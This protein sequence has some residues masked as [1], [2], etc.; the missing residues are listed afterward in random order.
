M[1]PGRLILCRNVFRQSLFRTHSCPEGWRVQQT[2]PPTFLFLQYSVFKEQTSLDAMSW[3]CPLLA[4]GPVECRSRGSLDFVSN[5]R[6]TQ[7]RNF[8]VAS[9]VAAVVGEAYI[10]GGG[11]GV[12]TDV[13]SFLNFFATAPVP[14]RQLLLRP[15]WIGGAWA[16]LSPERGLPAAGSMRPPLTHASALETPTPTPPMFSLY[17]ETTI[18]APFRSSRPAVHGAPG[19]YGTGRGL[20]GSHLPHIE[21]R[22]RRAVA[23][24]QGDLRSAPHRR[25]DTC[26]TRA[27]PFR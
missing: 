1:R 10:V 22:R 18:G 26:Q 23:I 9:S 17:K 6:E 2:L 19:L 3:A 14:Q 21:I 12:N 16:S 4:S 25:R 8:F 13:P 24:L 20:P 15:F 27:A 11:F 5:F 7:K